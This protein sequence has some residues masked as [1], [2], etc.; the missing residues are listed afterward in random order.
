MS[1]MHQLFVFIRDF[2]LVFLP[3]LTG[4]DVQYADR[5]DMQRIFSGVVK[6]S[7]FAWGPYEGG[8]AWAAPSCRIVRR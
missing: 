8:G 1:E 5:N 3:R 4:P 7:L 2:A 6:N